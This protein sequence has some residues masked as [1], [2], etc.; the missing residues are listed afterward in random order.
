MET[1]EAQGPA[2]SGDGGSDDRCPQ[3]AQDMAQPVEIERRTEEALDQGGCQQSLSRIA[4]GED[5]RAQEVSIAQEIGHDG[6]DHRPGHDRPSRARPKSDQCA[7]GNTGGRP[8]H[9]YAVWS[10]QGKAELCR[11]DIDATDHDGETAQTDPPPRR[12]NCVGSLGLHSQIFEHLAVSDG[13]YSITSS[14]RASSVGGT[15]SPGARAVT[16]LMTNW[17][18]VA[19]TTGRPAGLAPLRTWPEYTPTCRH[20]SGIAVP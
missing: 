17:N 15:S 9:G 10:E 8:E 5:N 4:Y 16:R 13:F 19:W 3:Q 12:V 14:A 6:R 1:G 11:E 7:R 20:M 2:D 18:L